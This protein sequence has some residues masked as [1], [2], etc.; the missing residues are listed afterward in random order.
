MVCLNVFQTTGSCL[1]RWHANEALCAKM[2]IDSALPVLIRLV[3]K[4][5]NVVIARPIVPTS[6]IHCLAVRFMIVRRDFVI[7]L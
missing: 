3:D 4:T 2:F 7:G 5:K 6:R 1:D